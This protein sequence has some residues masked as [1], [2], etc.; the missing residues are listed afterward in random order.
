MSATE[1]RGGVRA[2][3]AAVLALALA[4]ALPAWADAGDPADVRLT[5]RLGLGGNCRRGAWAPLWVRATNVGGAFAGALTATADDGAGG[6]ERHE[7]ALELAPGA[8]KDYWFYLK[9]PLGGPVRAGVESGGRRSEVDAA[10]GEEALGRLYLL[11][12]G[13]SGRAAVTAGLEAGLRAESGEWTRVVGA[14]AAS[15]PDAWAGYA[16]ADAVV[17]A[18]A[19]P[20]TF[21]RP[22][23]AAAF[24]AWVRSGGRA[25]VVA[26]GGGGAVRGTIFEELLP[27]TLGPLA[28][29]G[30]AAVFGVGT[31]AERDQAE[32][33]GRTI[34][35]VMVS[36]V[37]EGEGE[38]LFEQDG[39]PL[40]MRGRCGLGE[41]LLLTFDP[42][43]PPFDRWLE[44]APLWRE[45]DRRARPAA[46]PWGPAASR[47]LQ[48][49]L[50]SAPVGPPLRSL[51]LLFLLAAYAGVIGPG[52]WLLAR[53]RPGA[54]RLAATLLASAVLFGWMLY[55]AG[56]GN[57]SGLRSLRAAVLVDLNGQ[58][59]TGRVNTWC[60]FYAGEGG[61]FDVEGR[62]PGGMLRTGLGVEEG[63]SDPGAPARAGL[64]VASLGA[65]DTCW[66][67]GAERRL[68]GYPVPPA[69]I[70]FL[71]TERP[72]VAAGEFGVRA[73]RVGERVRVANGGR[74]RL[75]NLLVC[76]SGGVERY[77]P[78]LEP[79]ETWELRVPA[80]G[81][82]G[83]EAGR[84]WSGSGM[85][86]WPECAAALVRLLE[87]RSVRSG[88]LVDWAARSG[89]AGDA[90]EWLRQGGILVLARPEPPPEE[91]DVLGETPERLSACVLRLWVE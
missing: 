68:A 48:A 83:R 30:A 8:T 10:P 4:V 14:P 65:A 24:A 88:A 25:L 33:E 40:V 74:L 29:I 81:G 91:L 49:A 79:G 46:V 20:G 39:L 16:A 64:E 66:R 52:H 76:A 11:G 2:R 34:P 60:A 54:R 1:R 77:A 90:S 3:A 44:M 32:A 67:Y 42:A 82:W 43:V 47:P 21:E 31:R 27:A 57:R 9:Q 73:V 75:L 53:R 19:G 22:E 85:T 18:A 13:G 15:L 84:M 69:G 5:V 71:A 36:R 28:E 51:E 17:V 7:H 62:A 56:A 89:E 26:A 38:V 6:Q 45:L 12:G 37:A 87:G 80:G 59:G 58:D 41:V 50:E 23:Q 72:V 61:K 70:R 86:G 63:A 35:R 78:P 55:G